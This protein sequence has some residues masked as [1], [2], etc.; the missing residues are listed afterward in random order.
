[1]PH[2]TGKT[3]GFGRVSPESRPSPYTPVHLPTIAPTIAPGIAPATAAAAPAARAR[4]R[5]IAGVLTVV[6][7]AAASALAA[8]GFLRA[9]TR[10]TADA[11]PTPAARAT[12]LAQ[13]DE[14]GRLA[15]SAFAASSRGARP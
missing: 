2:A 12:L 14:A 13:D 1:M 7:V 6:V 11:T 9:A 15:R 5:R 3:Y 8:A 4:R 10:A